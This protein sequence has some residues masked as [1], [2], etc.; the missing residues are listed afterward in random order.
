MNSQ[1]F[2]IASQRYN[3]SKRCTE[4][5]EEK[6][7]EPIIHNL[8][9]EATLHAIAKP[10]DTITWIDEG[11]GKFTITKGET[12]IA[13]YHDKE[14]HTR[15]AFYEVDNSNK[16]LTLLRKQTMDTGYGQHNY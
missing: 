11:F 1:T 14:K 13:T 12:L 2:T 3:K 16:G 6:A 15:D 4:I 9:K 10:G 5:I 7:G 8:P